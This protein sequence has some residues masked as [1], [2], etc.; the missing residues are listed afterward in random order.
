V[1]TREGASSR[2]WPALPLPKV[3]GSAAAKA[4]EAAEADELGVLRVP[5]ATNAGVFALAPALMSPMKAT[6]SAVCNGAHPEKT[7]TPANVF[8]YV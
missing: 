1:R 5:C 8:G 2:R 3:A 6:S 7:T 4:A